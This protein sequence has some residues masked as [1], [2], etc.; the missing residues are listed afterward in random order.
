[1]MTVDVPPTA[2]SPYRI[3]A[4]GAALM[5]M[6]RA[7]RVLIPVIVVNAVVQAL[8]L[9]PGTLPY[10]SLPFVVLAVIGFVVMVISAGLVAATMLRPRGQAARLGEAARVV[11]DRLWPL[12]LWSVVLI[13]LVTVGLSLYVVPGLLVLAASP[14]LLLAVVDGQRRP[15][16][17]NL[18][19]IAARWARWLVTVVVMAAICAV[20]WLFSA[21]D[22]FF[23]TGAPAALIGWLVLG[24]VASWFLTAWALVYRSVHPAP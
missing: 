9:L 16:V 21:L 22:G 15:W 24:L 17:V 13:A 12:L 18:R 7:W 20:L 4:L 2:V 8:I 5:Q 6:G 14:F 10:L 3:S 19:V 23:V 11:K 1:M